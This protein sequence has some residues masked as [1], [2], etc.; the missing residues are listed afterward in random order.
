MN[1]LKILIVEDER[2]TAIDIQEQL[3]EFGYTDTFIAGDSSTA[4]QLFTSQAID[5]VLMDIQLGDSP[6]DGIALAEIFNNIRKVPIIYLTSHD[7][8]TQRAK[9]TKPANY[10]LKNCPK[11]QLSIAIDVAINAFSQQG[12]TVFVKT[13]NVYSR[14]GLT[15]QITFHKVNGIF[16]ILSPEDI[17]YCEADGAVTKVILYTMPPFVAT[18]HLG[19]YAERLEKDFN[20]FRIR[21]D[22]LVNLTYVKT[23]NHAER[24]VILKNGKKLTAGREGGKALR[25]LLNGE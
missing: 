18:R 20:F 10:L 8:I 12:D 5:F 3:L 17:L 16:E 2:L 7:Q 1:N 22:I 4:I 11:Q 21:Q 24:E 13:D 15:H 9:N 23:Y 25:S 6:I 14:R 19:F